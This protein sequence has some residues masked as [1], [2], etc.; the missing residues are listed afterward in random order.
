RRRGGRRRGHRPHAPRAV[1]GAPAAGAP[2]AR[3]TPAAAPLAELL[4]ALAPPLE[5]LA[6]D[7]FRR[8]DQTRLPLPALAERLARAPASGPP[9]RLHVG[10]GAAAGGEVG[11]VGGGRAGRR[12]R[13]VLEVVLR[14]GDGLLVLVWFHQI[15]YFSR[16]LREGQRLIVHG[17]VEPPL[18][19][20][21]KRI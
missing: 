8:L 20:G 19:G 12:G 16:R 13:R 2:P 15:P 7:D 1:H 5:Y 21:P 3:M 11:R 18:G 17:R 10:E 4:R 9:G 14:D 6:A